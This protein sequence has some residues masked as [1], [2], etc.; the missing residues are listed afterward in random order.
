MSRGLGYVQRRVMDEVNRIGSSDTFELTA[1]VF[2]VVP[3]ADGR[4]LLTRAQLGSVRRAIR[5]LIKLGLI[6]GGP[7]ERWPR[8][9]RGEVSSIAEDA[10]CQAH[11]RGWYARHCAIRAIFEAPIE[12]IDLD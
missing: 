6:S 8:T 4:R 7:G 1:A 9:A 2:V 10:R 12:D 5:K 3:D 11:V